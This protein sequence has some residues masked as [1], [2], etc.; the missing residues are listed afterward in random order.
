MTALLSIIRGLL[1]VTVFVAPFAIVGTLDYASAKKDEAFRCEM[2]RTFKE[3]G[4][5]YG[6]P[7]SGACKTGE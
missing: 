1:V 5:K 6:W 4:G 2:E 3:T 7:P